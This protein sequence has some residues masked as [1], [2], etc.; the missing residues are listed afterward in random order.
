MG[1]ILR[2]R[3]KS[4]WYTLL[5]ELIFDGINNEKCIL[6]T[7]QNATPVRIGYCRKNNN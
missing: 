2:H 3:N 4:F 6:S 7:I 5:I 1:L